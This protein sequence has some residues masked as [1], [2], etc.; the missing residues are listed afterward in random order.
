VKKCGTITLGTFLNHHPNISAK[1]EIHFFADDKLYE[2]G[3]QNYISQMPLASKEQ[4]VLVKTWAVW[5]QND[6][7]K[8]LERQKSHLPNLKILLIVRDPIVRL[9]SDVVQ[10]YSGNPNKSKTIDINR[11]VTGQ[12]EETKT[13]QY[14]PQ[15]QPARF[16]LF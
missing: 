13:K 7:I 16:F 12:D 5:N 9:V 11:I 15:G 3:I 2:K 10:F 1:G 8:V 14:Y 6:V 4:K